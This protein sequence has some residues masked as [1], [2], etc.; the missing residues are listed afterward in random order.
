ME[1]L[2]ERVPTGAGRHGRQTFGRVM[3]QPLLPRV[4]SAL[5]LFTSLSR[6]ARPP[7]KKPAVQSNHYLSQFSLHPATPGG[8]HGCLRGYRWEAVEPGSCAS[9]LCQ[10]QLPR[11]LR[12][13]LRLHVN[14]NFR[15]P[16]PGAHIGSSVRF[17]VW[18]QGRPCRLHTI[19]DCQAHSKALHTMC[20]RMLDLDVHGLSELGRG[21][22][23]HDTAHVCSRTRHLASRQSLLHA[24]LHWSIQ[25]IHALKLIS[26]QLTPG[27]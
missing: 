18:R 11:V 14:G 22:S 5:P 6:W 8:P 1:F 15:W 7:C 16:A 26:P 19:W 17:G 2:K 23:R 20:P 3:P 9:I 25:E 10:P 27:Q 4:G 12:V 13:T 21:S 24:L